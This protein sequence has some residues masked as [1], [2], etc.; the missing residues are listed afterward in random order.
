MKFSIKK[1]A[2]TILSLTLTGLSFAQSNDENTFNSYYIDHYNSNIVPQ[3]PNASNFTIYGDTPVNTSSGLPSISIPIFTVEEDGVQIPITLN[4]H[5]SGIKVDDISSTVGL[6]WSI[7]AGG[8]VFRTV[9]DFCDF[10]SGSGSGWIRGSQNSWFEDWLGANPNYNYYNNGNQNSF[11]SNVLAPYDNWPDEFNYNFLGYSGDFIFRP[12]GTILKARQEDNIN[13]VSSSVYGFTLEDPKGNSYNFVD[14]EYNTKN[15]FYYTENTTDLDIQRETNVVGW[16]LSSILTKNNK[17]IEF[18]YDT[19]NFEYQLNYTSQ[20]MVSAKYCEA[21]LEYCMAPLGCEGDGNPLLYNDMLKS[22]TT[23]DQ[24]ANQLI[25]FIYTD[26]VEVEFIYTDGPVNGTSISGWSKR[27]DKIV[28]KDKIQNKTKEFLFNYGYYENVDGNQRRLKLISLTEKGFDGSL[29]PPY[30]FSYNTTP[31]PKM[32]SRGKDYKGFYNGKNNNPSL[33][34]RT[35][36]S[37]NRTYIFGNPSSGGFSI[38][39]GYNKLSDRYFN[40]HYLKAGILEEIKYPTGGKTQFKYE[41]NALGANLNE[42][43]IQAVGATI[44]NDSS[45]FVYSNGPALSDHLYSTLV[46]IDNFV[47]KF[48][49]IPTAACPYCGGDPENVEVPRVAMY[50]WNGNIND[51]PSD[52]SKKGDEIFNTSIESSGYSPNTPKPPLDNGIYLLQLQIPEPPFP[53]IYDPNV[54]ISVDLNWFKK[55]TNQNGDVVYQENYFGGL[56]IAEIKDIDVNNLVYNHKKYTYHDGIVGE[57]FDSGRNYKELGGQKIFSSDIIHE[58]G[59]GMPSNGYTYTEITIENQGQTNNG[60]IKE[61]YAP[62]SSFTNIIGGNLIKA[63]VFD[64]NNN[65]LKIDTYTYENAGTTDYNYSFQIPSLVDEVTHIETVVCFVDPISGMMFTTTKEIAGYNN[66]TGVSHYLGGWQVLLSKKSTQFLS[67]NAGYQPVTTVNEFDYNDDLLVIYE[68]TDTRYTRQDDGNGNITYPLTHS[69]G[70]YVEVEYTYKSDYPGE[71]SLSGLPIGLP[72]S[73]EVKNKGQKIQGQFFEYDSFGNIKN[74]FQYNKGQ[75]SNNSPLNYIPTDYEQI[76]TYTFQQGK[77]VQI[78]QKD[79]TPTSYIYGYNHQYPV[80]KI[81]NMAYS[82][83]P[84]GLI[85]AIHTA[86]SPTGSQSQLITALNN[87]R[88]DSSMD[89]ALITTYTYNPLVGVTT[90]TAPNG[91]MVEYFY[92]G[93]GRLESITDKEGN[94]MQEF[95]YNYGDN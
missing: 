71:Q 91:D 39:H 23:I 45:I 25:R 13:I 34:P 27:I 3:T 40:E 52:P 60:K 31:L 83:I 68:K 74:V 89:T 73:K 53:D 10:G 92:D 46:T 26:N 67:S 28:I 66:Q 69:Q 1:S 37:L 85:S 56:R 77:P 72:V 87:L 24:T 6:K 8:G 42:P 43:M 75:G 63:K 55:Q 90:I 2:I 20:R 19:Y 41:A 82:S 78:L 44:S 18:V 22:T 95:E 32:S 4:Y 15:T 84:S 30:E 17:S 7:S 59:G 94:L 76:A 93:F 62:K 29:K 33:I 5:A 47:G 64:A 65:I 80:A 86:S 70:E 36:F 38:H 61:Y 14:R 49:F 21:S 58:H 9:K 11:K 79:G 54:L 88:A 50:K 57:T 81:E 16:M 35:V 12:D 48:E 51:D